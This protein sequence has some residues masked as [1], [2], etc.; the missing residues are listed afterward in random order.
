MLS[1]I[2]RQTSVVSVRWRTM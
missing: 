2:V 1:H